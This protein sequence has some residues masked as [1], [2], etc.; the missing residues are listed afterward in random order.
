[1]HI[2]GD[3]HSDKELFERIS[4]GDEKA[5]RKVFHAYN[6]ILFPF[7]VALMKSETEAREVMQEVFLKLWLQR[8]TL[9]SVENPGGWLRTLASNHAY[10]H[11]RK[12]ATY[13]RYLNE[14]HLQQPDAAGEFNDQQQAAQARELLRQAISRLPERRRQIFELSK[15]E[16]LSRREVA[17]LL[18]LSENTVRNQLAEAMDFLQRELQ[19]NIRDFSPILLWV[20]LQ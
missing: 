4:E 20:L 2:S 13:H 10:D 5:F 12:Q 8:S 1:M 11:L 17:N 3:I 6:K 7:V 16:G 19:K 15:L 14:M 18:E 9:R